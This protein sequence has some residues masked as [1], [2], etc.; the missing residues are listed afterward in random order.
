MTISSFNQKNV[1]CNFA[2][3]ELSE[4]DLF[5]N[6]KICKSFCR[7]QSLFNSK[8]DSINLTEAINCHTAH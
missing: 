1:N 3:P 5:N 7:S 2:N 8:K 6:R 4:S